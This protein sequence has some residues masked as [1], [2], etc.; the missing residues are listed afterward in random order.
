MK[1][2]KK[3][4]SNLKKKHAFCLYALKTE[5]SKLYYLDTYL[6]AKPAIE[7]KKLSEWF[8]AGGRK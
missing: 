4:N 3:K 1:K 6:V 2:K 7:S 8:I 5:K